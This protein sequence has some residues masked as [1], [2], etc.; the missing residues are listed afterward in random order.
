MFNNLTYKKKNQLLIIA[1]V[2]VVLLVYY[3]AVKETIHAY[4][5]YTDS[6]KKME[7]AA[8]APALVV[9]L[10][11]ELSRIDVKSGSQQKK[12]QNTAEALLSLITEYCQNNNAVLRDFPETSIATQ[13]DLLIETNRFVV[14][15]NFTT[16]INLVYLLEQKNKLGKIS[17]VKYQL[18]KDF[19]T[20]EMVL[21]ATIFLQN[22]K[23]QKIDQ[24]NTS[25]NEK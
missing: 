15:G 5:E 6:N 19:K 13:G 1:T 24:Q 16:L 21:T 2:V 9:K 23:K 3:I 4:S 17:S 11:N 10:K 25:S 14:A 22:I 12:E 8:N 18:K 20:K 7:V